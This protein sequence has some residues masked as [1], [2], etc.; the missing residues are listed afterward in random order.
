MKEIKSQGEGAVPKRL[1][2][3]VILSGIYIAFSLMGTVQSLFGGPLSEEEIQNEEL[4]F[5]EM[6]NEL[7]AEGIG[8]E[9][10]EM[11]EVMISTS[12]YINNEAFYLSNS[13]RLVELLVGAFSLFLMFHLKKIG[14]HL[15]IIY[16]FLPILITYIVLPM[17]LILT[18]SIIV[19]VLLGAFFALLYGRSLKDM[20]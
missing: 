11:A 10:T 4:Q 7:E 13:L 12:V 8:Q 17:E 18:A 20:S 9:F 16:S 1:K 5:Y 14:F 2:I 3:L 15:Y 19:S 6:I